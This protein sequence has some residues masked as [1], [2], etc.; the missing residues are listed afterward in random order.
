MRRWRLVDATVDIS[1]TPPSSDFLVVERKWPMVFPAQEDKVVFPESQCLDKV[2]AAYL[3]RTFDF[4]TLRMLVVRPFREET[5]EKNMIVLKKWLHIWYLGH[6]TSREGDNDDDNTYVLVHVQGDKPEQ[7]VY[8]P[9]GSLLPQVTIGNPPPQGCFGLVTTF[10]DL[11]T[12]LLSV[13][14][15]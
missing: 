1:S 8:V 2:V 3:V 13:A 6:A 9:R 5:A 15:I 12:R 11:P 7:D 4:D 14:T 10:F